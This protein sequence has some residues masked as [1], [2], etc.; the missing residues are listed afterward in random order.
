MPRPDLFDKMRRNRRMAAERAERAGFEVD[1]LWD[2]HRRAL[3]LERAEQGV[4]T[5]EW[6]RQARDEARAVVQ[7]R[8]P[9]ATRRWW[10]PW[11]RAAA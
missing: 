3:V 5:G 10:W 7:A 2:D 6:L 9:Q 1:E 4:D 11:A 8:Q